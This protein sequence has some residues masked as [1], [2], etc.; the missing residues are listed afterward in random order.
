MV[1]NMDNKETYVKLFDIRG[2][3]ND[4][5]LT[6]LLSFRETKRFTKLPV[7]GC[8]NYEL[9]KSQIIMTLVFVPLAAFVL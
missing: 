9:W 1:S 2:L 4:K 6:N 8:A 7:N 3:S 5:Y